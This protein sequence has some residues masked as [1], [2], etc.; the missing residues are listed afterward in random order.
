MRKRQDKKNHEAHAADVLVSALSAPEWKEAILAL[1]LDDAIAIDAESTRGR[2]DPASRRVRRFRLSYTLTRVAA[3]PYT[4][5]GASLFRIT[6]RDHPSVVIFA[7]EYPEAIG[8]AAG[9]DPRAKRLREWRR[10]EPQ[11]R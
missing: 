6:A 2:S 5:P 1:G 4:E 8:V 7:E 3:S 9:W 11:S 10:A